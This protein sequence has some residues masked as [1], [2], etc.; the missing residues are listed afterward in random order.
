MRANVCR[1]IGCAKSLLFVA[2]SAA[3]ATS[4]VPSEVIPPA[5][6]REYRAAWIA[7]VDNIDWPSTN[8]LSTAQQKTELLRIIDKAAGLKLNVLIFQV[9]PACDALYASKIEPWSEYLTGRMGQAPQPFWDPLAFAVEE[10]HR[11]AIELHAWF[12]PYRALHPSAEGPVARTHISK[13][14]PALVRHYGRHLWLDPGE[15]AVQQYSLDVVMD[16][17]RRYDVDGI[18]FDDYF[19]P[20]R[21]RGPNGRDIDF[22]DD[23]SWERTGRQ[24]GL[25]REDWRRQNVNAFVRRVYQEIKAAKPWV[26]FGVSPFG[27]WRP[28]H[29]AQIRGFD[30]YEGLY[31]DARKWLNEGWVDYFAP[32]LYWQIDPPAQ[33]FPVLLGWWAEQNVLGRHLVPGLNTTRAQRQW[34]PTEIVNQV[35]LTRKPGA[36]GHVHWNMGSLGRN[37]AL[38]QALLSGVYAQPA[39]PPPATWLGRNAPGQPKLSAAARASSVKLSW[40]PAGSTAL[41]V[42][43]VHEK[44]AGQWRARVLPRNARAHSVEGRPE[45]L[46]LTAF[47]RFGN[48]SAPAVLQLKT[49]RQDQR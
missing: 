3:A 41:S 16:V 5:P 18:H 17:V 8:G 11:R 4:Y 45:V 13:T 2:F 35:R 1:V 46:A 37:A 24:S 27:I 32:Q 29:P 36:H 19:Y 14:R 40:T 26:K 39:V 48:A 34:P 31:A 47:D 44:N 6:Q 21:E 28:G 30:A 10:C 33:S 9:R 7:T 22:P 15:P 43:V 20:Y 42:W 38:G 25:S 23:P 49:T 12:N